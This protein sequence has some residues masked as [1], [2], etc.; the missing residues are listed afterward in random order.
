MT[1]R[2][3]IYARYSSDLQ[4]P[5]SLEDQIS[6]CRRYIENGVLGRGSPVIEV[7]TDAALSGRTLEHRA[8]IQR[9]AR[10]LTR[11]TFTAVVTEHVDR[12]ARD[13]LDAAQIFKHIR[14]CGA[15]L[16]TTERPDALD[17]LYFGI[18][19]AMSAY[20]LENLADKTRRGHQGK[21]TRG[22]FP[23]GLSYGYRVVPSCY[24]KSG[25]LVKGERAIDPD[26]AQ[27]VRRIFREYADGFS[28]KV[29]ARRLNADGIPTQ[30]GGSWSPGSLLGS[31]KERRGLLHNRLYIGKLIY[32]RTRLKPGGHRRVLLNPEQEWIVAERPDLRIVEDAVWHK[33]Q[34]RLEQTLA[35]QASGRLQGRRSEDTLLSSEA[36]ARL[37]R[38]LLP[39][40]GGR[41]LGLVFC[42]P[43]G[44][45]KI[46]SG[47]RHYICA[48]A[49]Q[50]GTC[51]NFRSTPETA[52]RAQFVREALARLERLDVWGAVSHRGC[53]ETRRARVETQRQLKRTEV[54]IERLVLALEDG[55]DLDVAKARL[56]VLRERQ[57]HLA[58]LLRVEE[59]EDP[60]WTDPL[61]EARRVLQLLSGLLP[62]EARVPYAVLMPCVVARV[63]CEPLASHYRGEVVEISWDDQGWPAFLRK[64]HT[65][66][67]RRE[68]P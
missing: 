17:T 20:H 59:A 34:A 55:L 5:T 13:Q 15:V 61:G 41:L 56:A 48:Q 30:R 8:G 21:A 44:S 39:E 12:L 66:W 51:R 4:K 50:A 63:D 16:Y 47:R 10:D 28:L 54:A 11:Y 2:L 1:T 9:L 65:L 53:D 26:Q 33:V 32:N 42:K 40:S 52:L 31:I 22:L 35:K 29:I 68:T 45:R 38:G 46:L 7:Y 62:D 36:S 58:S 19:G 24:D 25:S 60:V 14:T 64:A 18:R 23:A 27:V 3:A 49:K 37:L 57:Q 67:P 43:C 6:L